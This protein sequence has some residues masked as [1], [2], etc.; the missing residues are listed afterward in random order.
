[1]RARFFSMPMAVTSQK[2]ETPGL[3]VL[4]LCL[5]LAIAEQI[6]SSTVAQAIQHSE[7]IECLR[8]SSSKDSSTQAY[9]IS[10][11][12]TFRSSLGYYCTR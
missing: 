4:A 8:S 11:L 2:N 5:A 12:P 6:V 7:T 3:A 9:G 10:I 1:V